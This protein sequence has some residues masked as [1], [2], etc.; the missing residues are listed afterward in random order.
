MAPAL[1]LGARELLSISPPL[2]LQQIPRNW[3]TSVRTR[4]ICRFS[5]S[6]PLPAACKMVAARSAFLQFFS[7]PPPPALLSIHIPAPQKVIQMRCC[8]NRLPK[9]G[10]PLVRKLNNH[11]NMAINKAKMMRKQTYGAIEHAGAKVMTKSHRR[12]FAACAHAYVIYVVATR[13]WSWTHT[14]NE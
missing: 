11:T 9:W 10:V 1:D 4:A 6:Q 12:S 13:N 2:L 3:R 14:G 5:G 8:R 7:S